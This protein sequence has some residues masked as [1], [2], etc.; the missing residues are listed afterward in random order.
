MFAGWMKGGTASHPLS[1]WQKVRKKNTT[2]TG[3]WKKGLRGR[4][5]HRHARATLRKLK[6]W[7]GPGVSARVFHLPSLT[8]RKSDVHQQER[9]Q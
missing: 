9:H 3:K 8:E 1:R 7:F 6:M 5:G 2:E 4:A